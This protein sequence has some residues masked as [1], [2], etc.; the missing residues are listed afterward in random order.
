MSICADA[1]RQHTLVY[2]TERRDL[3]ILD[4]G[5][6]LQV[7]V[8]SAVNAANGDANAIVGAQCALRTTEGA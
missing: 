5:I 8:S 7:I 1:L 4:L 3:H 2:V 6:V